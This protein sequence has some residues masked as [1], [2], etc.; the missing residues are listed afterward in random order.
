MSTGPNG[1]SSSPA[2]CGFRRLRSASEPAK[3]P[4]TSPHSSS[5][6]EETTQPM[7]ETYRGK[8]VSIHPDQTQDP[9]LLSLPSHRGLK[10]LFELNCNPLSRFKLASFKYSFNKH[11]L[12][13][14]LYQ[15][16][17]WVSWRENNE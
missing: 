3:A 8:E 2:F 14:I 10:T 11:S 5:W 6:R 9:S 13:P 12:M 16:L 7:M 15:E 1:A 17:C 4:F